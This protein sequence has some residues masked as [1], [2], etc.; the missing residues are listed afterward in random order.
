MV[1]TP[2]AAVIKEL[3]TQAISH[4]MT[5]AVK[6]IATGRS[7]SLADYHNLSESEKQQ[8]HHLARHSRVET[9][10]PNPKQ[11]DEDADLRRFE[12]LRGERV[13][14]NDSSEILKELKELLKKFVKE[15]RLPRAE[16]NA[17][18]M[19]LL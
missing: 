3:P 17:I 12:I 16:V 8:L 19:E 2:S 1:K 15:G 14:G 4:N 13:A 9:D 7:V 10:L 18:L 6:T 11:S 5:R